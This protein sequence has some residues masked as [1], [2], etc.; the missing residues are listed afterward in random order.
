MRAV[1]AFLVLSA[2][3]C[4]SGTPHISI[5]EAPLV[6]FGDLFVL[7]DTVRLDPA[8]I[9]GQIAFLDVNA[10]GDLL[11]ADDFGRATHL[12]SQSGEHKRSYTV[13]D[14][15]PDDAETFAPWV[16]RF[17]GA[18]R[19][20]TMAGSGGGAVVFGP[21]GDCQGATRHLTQSVYDVCTREDSIF[22]LRNATTAS[23]AAVLVYSPELARIGELAVNQ[24]EFVSLNFLSRGLQ[25]RSMECF[26]DGAYHVFRESMDG[27]PV[28]SR[29]L[30]VQYR[31]VF[32]EARPSDLTP[33]AGIEVH[34]QESSA[35][36]S[37]SGIFALEDHTR[38]VFFT[39]LDDKWTLPG[40]DSYTPA[41]MIVASNAEHFP[42]R[43]TLAPISPIAGGNGY[44]YSLGDNELLPDGD[45]GNQ[46]IVRYRF[47][48][49][50]HADD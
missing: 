36:P 46:V 17:M 6:P 33:F 8:I 20:F 22:V 48:T 45:I 27:I 14:C 42:A 50:E 5:S 30:P 10:Q 15:L 12:F 43:S 24:T 40:S 23:E 26:A 13:S 28:R 41:G 19:I 49:P 25:A 2:F 7:E 18:N 16:S 38:M 34:L 47:V 39:N 29:S 44:M 31:P 11:V 35:Y 4:N 3:G 32:F 37:A 21:E 1:L 9:V